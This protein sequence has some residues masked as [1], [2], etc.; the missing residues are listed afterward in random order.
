MSEDPGQGGAVAVVGWGC[1]LP[2]ALTPEELWTLVGEGRDALGPVPPQRWAVDAG[3]M[4]AQG[5]DD[6]ADKTWVLHLMRRLERLFA[7]ARPLPGRGPDG[8]LR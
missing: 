4:L 8:S 2:G 7:D 5:P 3:R 1:V 6:G